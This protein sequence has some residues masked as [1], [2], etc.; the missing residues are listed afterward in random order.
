[1]YNK[2]W[3][4]PFVSVQ[5]TDEFIRFVFSSFRS[6]ATPHRGFASLFRVLE[7]SITILQVLIVSELRIPV[8]QF[9]VSKFRIVGAQFHVFQFRPFPF[10]IYIYCLILISVRDSFRPKQI[11]TRASE[12]M[13]P[14]TN[15]AGNSH[16]WICRK[17]AKREC[18]QQ[19]WSED[20]NTITSSPTNQYI[21]YLTL[22]SIY[23]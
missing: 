8:S 11:V 16:Q 6:F 9:R 15:T 23:Q 12:N 19:L 4:L 17:S 21:A 18:S 10:I 13:N 3:D 20:Q 14:Q 2:V 22:E 5:C 1:M 7:F